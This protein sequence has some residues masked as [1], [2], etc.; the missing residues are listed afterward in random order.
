MRNIIGGKHELIKD[1][2]VLYFIRNVHKSHCFL[3]LE[4]LNGKNQRTLKMAHLIYKNDS[5]QITGQDMVKAQ[6][7][8]F[9]TDLNL[10]PLKVEECEYRC[11]DINLKEKNIVEEKI[12]GF[13]VQGDLSYCFI[14][15]T[16]IAGSVGASLDASNMQE[17]KVASIACLENEVHA[18]QNVK[19]FSA[20]STL[21]AA[22]VCRGVLQEGH[23]CVSWA[24]TI[25]SSVRPEI[26]EDAFVGKY[27]AAVPQIELPAWRCVML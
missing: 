21:F 25:V 24:E 8:Y 20:A 26:L 14:G 9:D 13:V 5:S 3:L 1:Y 16:K 15:N 17:T 7:K 27:L 22:Q 23:N 4:G 12:N 11:W 6:V 2:W 18:K 10:L 19:G